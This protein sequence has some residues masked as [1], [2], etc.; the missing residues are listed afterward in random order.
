MTGD[1]VVLELR[2]ARLAS[3]GLAF[4]LDVLVQAVLLVALVLVV[5]LAGPDDGALRAAV[6]LSVLVLVRV[7]YPVLFET[8]TGGRTLGKMAF[9]LRV[10]RDDGG[11][12]RFRQALTRGLAGAIVDFGPVPV[13]SIVALVVSLCS[14]KSK[15]V[16]DFLAGTVVV[17]ERAPETPAPMISMPPMLMT[18]AQGLELSGL[19]DDLALAARQYLGRY[20]ALRPDARDALGYRLTHEVASWIGTPPPPEVPPWMYLMAVLAERRNRLAG[21]TSGQPYPPGQGG[22]FA[23][24]G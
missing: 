1:A 7:G 16:G 10:V 14:S 21:T 19:P 22:P 23:P 20:S 9:G 17:Q 4:A 12:I 18:W 8:L 2:L 6:L 5:V 24:P 15:R 13:W 11:P 3:R